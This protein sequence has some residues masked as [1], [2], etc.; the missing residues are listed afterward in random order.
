MRKTIDGL[1]I[2]E[3]S[4]GEN[5][6]ILTVLTAS[7]GK[8]SVI[9]KGA[10]SPRSKNLA[11]CR[12]FSY[13]NLEYYEKAGRRYLACGSVIDSFFELNSDMEGFA[14]ASYV[15]DVTNEISGENN[16]DTELLRA[17]L[18]TLYAISKRLRP[19]YQIKGAFEFFASSHSGFAP[20]M[21]HCGVCGSEGC[22]SGFCLDVMNGSLICSDCLSDRQKMPYDRSPSDLPEYDRFSTRNILIP[23]S[24]EVIMAI[25]YSCAAPTKRLFSFSLSRNEDIELFSKAGET[26]LQNHL[27][28]SFETLDFFH[29]V[30]APVKET[31]K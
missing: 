28:R 7:L 23:L 26:Y 15:A 1:V 11:V 2:R 27:E 21:S 5:D 17:V 12:I 3:S 10:R 25:R 31:K 6:K 14:L 18:N 8:I 4:V 16:A 30:C 22:E 13:S 19:L 20:D 24:A 29:T 9:A